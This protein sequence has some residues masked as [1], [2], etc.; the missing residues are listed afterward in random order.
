[1]FL[2]VFVLVCA[3]L[4]GLSV[5]ALMFAVVRPHKG[6]GM[7]A[8]ALFSAMLALQWFV[9]PSSSTLDQALAGC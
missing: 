2:I 3:I 4:M 7:A 8:A 5:T 9:R 6:Y 1:M